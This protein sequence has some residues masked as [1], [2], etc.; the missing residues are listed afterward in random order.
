M[1][2]PH[3]FR[4]Q[5]L[6]FITILSG[7]NELIHVRLIFSGVLGL[8]GAAGEMRIIVLFVENNVFDK[9]II[10]CICNVLYIHSLFRIKSPPCGGLTQ[11][12]GS[13]KIPVEPDP[14]TKFRAPGSGVRGIEVSHVVVRDLA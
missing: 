1:K 4:R 9:V 14:D 2:L 7:T 13:P 6:T 10:S 11:V 3:L 12:K 8:Q 5:L